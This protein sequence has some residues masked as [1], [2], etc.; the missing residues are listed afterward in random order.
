VGNRVVLPERY[1]DEYL[2]IPK[3]EI[4]NRL[5]IGDNG[6]ERRQLD[7]GTR[8]ILVFGKD[9]E[10]IHRIVKTLHIEEGP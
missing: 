6:I 4:Q 7:D 5:K 8:V 3:K 10:S 9:N 2:P 1:H